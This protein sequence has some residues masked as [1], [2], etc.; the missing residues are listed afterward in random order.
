MKRNLIKRT[1][2]LDLDRYTSPIYEAFE[3][4]INTGTPPPTE[5]MEAAAAWI[6]RYLRAGQKDAASAMQDR[7]EMWMR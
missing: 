6:R 7:M 1:A 5:I 3:K 2:N 4:A